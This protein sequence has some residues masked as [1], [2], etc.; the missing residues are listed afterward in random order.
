MI[1]EAKEDGL[2]PLCFME[3][4]TSEKKSMFKIQSSSVH[5]LGG[6]RHGN[7]A[8]LQAFL[9]KKLINNENIKRMSLFNKHYRNSWRLTY[10]AYL[11]RET[12]GTETEI[13]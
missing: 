12:Q 8:S 7:I 3:A 5:Q 2:R 11:I 1:A 4:K 6:D 10:L 9:K 13:G